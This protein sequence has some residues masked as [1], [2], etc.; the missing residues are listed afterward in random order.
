MLLHLVGEADVRREVRKL[1]GTPRSVEVDVHAVALNDGH[2]AK[3]GCFLD[4]P[5]SA[6]RGS[7]R[8]PGHDAGDPSD[9]PLR[10]QDQASDG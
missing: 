10:R 6:T 2:Q 4:R 8:P 9:R 7:N 3:P 1:A 5:R